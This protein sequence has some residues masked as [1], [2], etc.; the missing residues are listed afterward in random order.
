METST[1]NTL[2]IQKIIKDLLFPAEHFARLQANA[3]Q[4]EATAWQEIRTWYEPD[5]ADFDR[6]FAKPAAVRR[7]VTE[8][9]AAY[10]LEEATE[11]LLA[12]LYLKHRELFLRYDWDFYRHETG[13]HFAPAID[14]DYQYVVNA[15]GYRACS[16]AV[17]DIV[18]FDELDPTAIP[19]DPFYPVD[20]VWEQLRSDHQLAVGL[21]EYAK[22]LE[23]IECAFRGILHRHA[24]R[25]SPLFVMGNLATWVQKIEEEPAR[26][27]NYIALVVHA[28]LLQGLLDR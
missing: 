17:G 8:I 11:T 14:E 28:R 16:A 23:P 19:F 22:A 12:Y 2:T 13:Y 9:C 24:G 27:S 7:M 6:S 15:F 18:D 3:K 20:Q 1:T 4:M 26:L 10:D 25:T 21:I 5:P